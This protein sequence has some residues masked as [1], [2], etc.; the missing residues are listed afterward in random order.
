MD[1]IEYYYLQTNKNYQSKDYYHA[2]TFARKVLE[3][4]LRTICF[5]LDLESQSIKEMIPDIKKK[6]QSL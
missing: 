3:Q 6:K 1:K 5:N 4:I 2:I